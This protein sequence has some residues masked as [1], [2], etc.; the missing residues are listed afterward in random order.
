L[1]VSCSTGDFNKGQRE[2]VKSLEQN[3]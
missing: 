2:R 1:F 3:R